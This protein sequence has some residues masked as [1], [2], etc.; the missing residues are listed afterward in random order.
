MAEKRASF[1]GMRGKKAAFHG[2][3]GK[4]DA[5]SLALQDLADP[6][7]PS[8]SSARPH[9]RGLNHISAVQ[10]IYGGTHFHFILT[11]IQRDEYSV[12]IKNFRRFRAGCTF[13]I[14]TPIR[15]NEIL[16]PND[17][18]SVLEKLFD[19]E[20]QQRSTSL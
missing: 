1:T 18:G 2:M 5:D 11:Y 6:V 4:K 9:T 7:G 12:Y 13:S 3:R 19:E 20:R 15:K 10:I 17:N 14:S 8:W 16:F